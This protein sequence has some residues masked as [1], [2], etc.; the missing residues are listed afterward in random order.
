MIKPEKVREMSEKGMFPIPHQLAFLAE[1][2]I[3]YFVPVKDFEAK[4]IN[5]EEVNKEQDRR[6]VIYSKVRA[7]LYR[8]AANYVSGKDETRFLRKARA[9]DASAEK[10]SS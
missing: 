8:V 10:Y 7:A 2:L 1:Q 6:Y 3:Y 4:R 9:A 5:E